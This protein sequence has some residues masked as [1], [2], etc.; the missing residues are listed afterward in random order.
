MAHL[1]YI[2]EPENIF[3]C[4]ETQQHTQYPSFTHN[5]TYAHS[6]THTHIH[7]FRYTPLCI[8]KNQVSCEQR[9]EK[10]IET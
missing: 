2:S 5:Y 6:H 3:T 10:K 7:M 9:F 8:F 1:G 4:S